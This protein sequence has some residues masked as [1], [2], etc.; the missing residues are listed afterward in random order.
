M[1]D[2]EELKLTVSLTDDASAGLATIRTQL[3]QLTQT[4]GQV[5]TALSGVASSAQQVGQAHRD[6][7]PHVN[8]QEKALKDLAKS[9]EETTRGLVQMALS[10][11]GGIG[12]FADLALGARGAM[13]GL[14]GVNESMAAL[15]ASSRLMVVGLGGVALGVAAIGAAVVAYGISVFKFSQE[16]YTLSQTA[17]ALGTTFGQLRNMTEQNE[18]F[19]VS[20]EQ[21]TAQLA[22]MNEV[23]TD[24]S[25]SGSRLR[26][27]MLSMGVPPK[28]IDDFAKL[29]DEVDRYNKAREYEQQVYDNWM[30]RTHG[31]TA[32]AATEASRAG[33]MFGDITGTAYTRDPMQKQTEEEKRAAAEIAKQSALIAEQWREIS[34]II[35]DMT[36]KFLAWGLP[37]TLTVVQNLK[38]TFEDIGKIVDAIATAWNKT[39]GAAN[40]VIQGGASAFNKFFGYDKLSDEELAKMG[41]SRVPAAGKGATGSW[42]QQPIEHRQG[43]GPV[44]SGQPYIVGE[45]GPE[46]MM[47]DSSGVIVPYGRVG[48]VSGGRIGGR[49]GSNDNQPDKLADETEKN[50][51]ETAKLTEQ[52]TK[53][54][55]YFDGTGSGGTG[56][57]PRML[58]GGSG[59]FGG[60]GGGGGGGGDSGDA[61]APGGRPRTAPCGG[62]VPGSMAD[63]DSVSARA[64]ACVNSRWWCRACSRGGGIK[65]SIWCRARW[66]VERRRKP[67][68]RGYPASQNATKWRRRC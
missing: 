24:L 47:P 55:D 68:L 48:G 30:R 33:K 43:G 46:I 17:K 4:A 54:N 12:G 19:G 32:I 42:D 7:A 45:H 11:R 44:K 57:V 59:R 65:D 23:V 15:G 36:T 22:S 2:F 67:R 50:T 10:T 53:L 64:D 6:A 21:T 37:E 27:Q 49:G 39:F 18:R 3:T 13:V 8:R 52:L 56:Q 63:A 38:A 9:A 25:L 41:I 35:S 40:R 5:Q 66:W 14:Q 16:M 28:A 61:I 60:G 58:G 34:K 20:A 1:A 29:T 62:T 31:N 51:T 26:Q